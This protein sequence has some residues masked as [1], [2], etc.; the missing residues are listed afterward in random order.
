MLQ[1]EEDKDN[2]LRIL[3]R[4]GMSGHF[5]FAP[6][7]EEIKHAHLSFFTK[8]D[9]AKMAL[10]FVDVRR[11][12]SWEPCDTWGTDRGPDPMFDYE[13]FRANVLDNLS[14][15]N[16]VFNKAICEVMLEQ[17]FFNGIG[18]YLRSEIL[19]RAEVPPFTCART[20]LEQVKEGTQKSPDFL[21]LCHDVPK[22]VINLGTG[23][24]YDLTSNIEDHEDFNK[25]LQCYNNPDLD[26]MADHNKRMVWFKGDPG[27]M[28]PKGASVKKKPAAKAKQGSGTTKK[29]TKKKSATT[30]NETKQEKDETDDA[31]PTDDQEEAPTTSSKEET[32]TI[33]KETANTE[34]EVKE[35]ISTATSGSKEETATTLRPRRGKRKAPE[36]KEAEEETKPKRRKRGSKK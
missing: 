26:S 29:D 10:H 8:D 20:V 31:A 18:N 14:R 7:D 27:P 19:Y 4:F 34:E 15:K 23:K 3:F 22:E 12:G 16:K 5:K 6:A 35:E 33:S 2:K 30:K 36:P 28:A 1:C 9:G 11:F 24:N 32:T 21:Q 13:K 17:K 25:W